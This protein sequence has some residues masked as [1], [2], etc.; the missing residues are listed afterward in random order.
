METDSAYKIALPVEGA[1]TRMG[2]GAGPATSRERALFSFFL[3]LAFNIS[4]A[5]PLYHYLRVAQHTVA[6]TQPGNN[7]SSLRTPH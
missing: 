6:D 2:L 3:C 5:I 7:T 4:V 1:E